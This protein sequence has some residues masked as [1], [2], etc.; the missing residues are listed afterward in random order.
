M[1][2]H[3]IHN[4]ENK[5]ITKL[6]Y[7]YFWP[8]FIGVIANSLYNIID[9]I[10]IGQGVGAEALSG[11]TAVF[12]IMIII[13]AFGMLIGMGSGVK[14]SIFLG[15]KKHYKAEMVLG[16]MFL[17]I[18]IISF[19]VT[20]LGFV[21]K[22]PILEIFGATQTTIT[23]ANDYLNIILYGV[24]FQMIG[25]SLN[26]IIRA[27][28]NAKIAMVSMILAAGINIP[29]DYLFIMVF[30][31][32][33]QG[34]AYATIISMMSLSIWVLFHFTGKNCVVKLKLKRIKYNPTIVKGVVAIGFAPF[35]MQIASSFVQGIYNT[36]LIKYGGDLAVGAF[37]IVIS[38]SVFIIMSIIALNMATQPIIGFNYGARNY[39]RVKKTLKIS[40]VTASIISLV[41]WTLIQLFPEPVI[42]LF[43]K[44]NPVLLKYGIQGIRLFLMMLPIIGFQIVISGYFQSVGKAKQA[45]LLSLL[46][47]VIFLTPLLLILPHYMGLKGIWLASP[48]SD[49]LSG[50]ISS[51]FMITEWKKHFR[52]LPN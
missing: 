45:T 50:I 38:V 40:L 19:L 27:E 31:W 26:N 43:N 23:Y 6:M 35:S 51:I 32:G 24:I 14:L 21:I 42:N 10:F 47:Q 9:R 37:G 39:L 3:Q 8:A 44:D 20:I 49:T 33:V 28:G 13:M 22:K 11:I 4:L 52:F 16:N 36:Q 34:A 41:A 30:K 17:L 46:R 12:P 25:F 18:I 2:K 7:Q 29:L 48:I 15:E 1:S 5:S